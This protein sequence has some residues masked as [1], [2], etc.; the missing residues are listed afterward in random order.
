MSWVSLRA[1]IEP[2]ST[3]PDDSRREYILNILLVA[4]IVLALAANIGLLFAQNAELTAPTVLLQ[5]ITLS[6]V[7]MFLFSRAGHVKVVATIFIACFMACGFL[8][9]YFWGIN[10]PQAML[11]FALCIVMAGILIGTKTAFSITGI[12]AAGIYYN[13]HLEISGRTAASALEGLQPLL[14]S[15]AIVYSITLA[16]I[17]V[18]S[19][20]SN[21]EIEK[22]LLRARASEAALK[23][24]RD[25]LEVKVEERTHEIRQLQLEKVRELYRFADFGRL[26]SGLFHDLVNP[27][28][29]VSLNLERLSNND[30]SEIVK[31]A[32]HGTKQMERFVQAVRRQVQG[33][34]SAMVFDLATEIQS[35]MSVLRHKA[36]S[37][38]VM[39]SLKMADSIHTYGSPVRFSQLMSNLIANAIDAF[40]DAPNTN[41]VVTIAIDRRGGEAVVAVTDTGKGIRAQDLAKVFEAFYTTKSVDKGTGVGLYLTREIVEKDFHGTIDLVSQPGQGSTFT[42]TFPI[43]QQ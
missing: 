13:T 17:A 9:T 40:E 21:R 19:W 20:L 29:M 15:D 18:V 7:A 1:Y 2:K 25:L 35:V 30:A 42:V 24:E 33:Q 8:T 11:I 28:T 3:N 27:L 38:Q 12:I 41:R 16:I 36:A 31:R 5:A 10:V 6:F 23:Q 4:S 37:E 43:R 22:S 39:L 34:S 14:Y 26:T 32:V